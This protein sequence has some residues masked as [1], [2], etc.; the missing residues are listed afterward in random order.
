M[1]S[2][3]G[4][5]TGGWGRLS[6]KSEAREVPLV[7][8][9]GRPQAE[10]FTD[11]GAAVPLAEGLSALLVL[12]ALACCGRTFAAAELPA[13][14]RRLGAIFNNDINNI[15]WASS[16]KA[17]SAAEY[18]YAVTRLLECRPGVLAQNVGMPDPVIYRSQV[19]TTWDKYTTEMRMV[20][21]PESKPLEAAREADAI[22]KLFAAGTDPLQITLEACRQRG[23]PCVASYRMN[24]E[25]WYEHT[26]ELSD[27][28]RAHPD[29]RIPGAGCLDP[30]VPGV[31]RHDLALF[32]DLLAHYA[33]DGIELDFRRW[34]HMI[35][36]PTTN[37][38]ILTQMVRDT[39]RLLDAAAKRQGRGRLLLG[40]RVGPM[41]EGEFRKEDFPGSYYGPPT[42]MSCHDLG[43]DVRTWIAEGLVDYVCPTLFEPLGLPRTREFADLA[44]GHNVGIYPTLS[45]SPTWTQGPAPADLTDSAQF[46]RAAIREW[47]RE[48]LRCYGDGAD[49][50]SV[51]N[52]WPHLYPRRGDGYQGWGRKRQWS[53]NHQDSMASVALGQAQGGMVPLLSDQKALGEGAEE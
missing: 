28:G 53:S 20:V 35:S 15:L 22:R 5:N 30:A 12:A 39:R 16:G 40:V 45:Q 46:R 41:L 23:V 31:Y 48:A 21:W 1:P 36:D 17:T 14:N 44:R 27:F 34:Y 37:Y 32:R 3:P 49:G 26:W 2:A 29:W 42:N 19:A 8:V 6:P 52:W 47:C 43:L 51:F 11:H 24:A 25:D 38:P 33:V 50:V 9:R 7:N 10:Q 13:D 18:R 4:N